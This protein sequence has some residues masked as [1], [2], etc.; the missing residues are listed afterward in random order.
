MDAML[1]DKM[2]NLLPPPSPIDTGILESGRPLVRP[3]AQVDAFGASRS[4]RGGK[5]SCKDAMRA[6]RKGRF[7]PPSRLDGVGVP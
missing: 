1:S 6:R 4:I 2:K 3:Q 5:G 7:L